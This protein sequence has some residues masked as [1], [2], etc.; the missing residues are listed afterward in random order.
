M[1]SYISNMIIIPKASKF[2]SILFVLIALQLL[3][4]AP[5]PP[6]ETGIFKKN[7]L[8]EL[9]NIDSSIKL[10]IRYATSNNFADQPVYEEARA[11]L[12]RPEAEAL[13]R[14]NNNLKK[15]GYGLLVFD[16]YRP[17]SVTKLF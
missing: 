10:D 15:L 14:V 17:W 5:R 6:Q 16:G 11:F 1:L 2:F 9:I 12:Q 8:V 4:C 13:I 7:D 3:G